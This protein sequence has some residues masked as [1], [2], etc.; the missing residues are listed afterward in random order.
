[1]ARPA[2]KARAMMNKWVAMRDGENRPGGGGGG[3]RSSRSHNKRPFRAADCEHLADAERFRGQIVREITT[4]MAQ[5]QNPA[6]P[7]H[8]VRTLNDSINKLQREKYHWNKRIVQLGGIDYNALEKKRRIEQGDTQLHSIYRYYGVAKDLPGVQEHLE[9]EAR[10]R[11]KLK[12]KR[13]DW[14]KHVSPEYYG[15]R[16]EDDGVL[17]ELETAAATRAQLLRPR[18]S[19]TTNNYDHV[20]GDVETGGDDFFASVPSQMEI[21]AL[22]LA[23]KKKALMEKF[24]L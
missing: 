14:H 7:E 23:E 5:I 6:L 8:E 21:A 16:D 3:D 18:E 12:N 10:A 9:Q 11:H 22:L 15:W 17:L 4:K 19:K 20:V 13:A 24:D 1:M 2:E